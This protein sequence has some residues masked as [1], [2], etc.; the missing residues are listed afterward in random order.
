MRKVL[1]VATILASF[2]RASAAELPK[3]LG[4]PG[5][6]FK[7]SERTVGIYVFH[8]YSPRA[9]QTKSVWKPLE[10]RENWDG[11][12]DF[13]KRQVKDI[14]D[15]NVDI[16]YV[17]LIDEHEDKRVNLFQAY[18]DLRAGGYR[19]PSI[20]PFLDPAI[21]FYGHGKHMP[22]VNM[23]IPRDRD[24]FSEQ[25]ARFYDQYFSVN[26]DEDAASYLGMMDG[27]PMLNVWSV[28]APQMKSKDALERQH[29]EG[30]LRERFPDLFAKGVFMSSI[31]PDKTGLAWS[32]EWN[33]SFVGYCGAYWL[34]DKGVASLKPG[35]YDTL[36]RFL[37]RDG[38]KGYAAA[39]DDIIADRSIQRVLLESWNEYTEGTGTYEVAN[40]E[41]DWSDPGYKPHPDVWGE[42]P[43]TYIDITAEKAARFNTIPDLDAKV[44]WHN[45]PEKMK[46]GETAKVTMIVR[47]EGDR[48]WS[49]GLYLAQIQPGEGVFLERGIPLDFAANEGPKYG[50]IFRGRPVRFDSE[51]TAPEEPGEYS[52]KWGMT[53]LGGRPLGETVGWK[54]R[55]VVN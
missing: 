13:W 49:G 47:N 9:G 43:R 34:K 51:I 38:G 22:N 2:G 42:S 32:D 46:P 5:S 35:H 48:E 16:M 24:A 28:G 26:T 8:W 31:I 12:V 33:R 18:A 20:V 17:H 40:L 39:W 37:A 3:Y 19:P 54:I 14:M 21:T 11:S 10:G 7:S 55:V 44:L 50:G 52:T 23:S 53:M 1:F 27:K 15:A 36:D 30:Y 25:Y 6:A 45:L 29:V 4:T 41:P